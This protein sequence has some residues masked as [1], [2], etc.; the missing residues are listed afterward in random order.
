MTLPGPDPRRLPTGADG[1]YHVLLRVEVSDDKE[2]DSSLSAAGA[3]AGVVHGG[4][5]AGFPL[6]PLRYV[7]GGA[8]TRAAA[9]SA[10]TIGL[11]APTTGTPWRVGESV[12]VEWRSDGSASAYRVDVEGDAG[13]VLFSA[14]VDAGSR[15]YR[16]PPWVRDRAP[17]ARA[18]RWRVVAIDSGGSETGGSDW[19][20]LLTPSGAP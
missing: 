20:T 9:A 18:L 8:R 6:P 11:V 7:V 17:V 14:L 13:T 10:R 12:E 19:W 16:L 15:R 4:A 5:V 2:G 3:G 1:I